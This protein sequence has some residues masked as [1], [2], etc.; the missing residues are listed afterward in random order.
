MQNTVSHLIVILSISSEVSNTPST[1]DIASD[2]TGLPAPKKVI[3]HWKGRREAFVL[4][5]VI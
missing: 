3:M 4:S 1:R 2:I 5:K